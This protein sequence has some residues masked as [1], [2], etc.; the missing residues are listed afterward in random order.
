[1][2]LKLIIL[3]SFFATIH[4]SAQ[5]PLGIWKNVDDEDGQDKSH[6]EIYE[7]DGKLYGKVVKLLPAATLTHCNACKGDHKGKSLIGLDI[8][9]SL[10]KNKKV[11]DNGEILDPKSGKIYDCKIELDGNDKL[12]VRGFIGVSMFGRTQIWYRVK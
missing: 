5:S 6:I 9:W 8:L 2:P 11:W 3:F 1:M 10:K 7:K 12:K 4:L